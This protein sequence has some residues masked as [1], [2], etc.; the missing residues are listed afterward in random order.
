GSRGQFGWLEEKRSPQIPIPKRLPKILPIRIWKY[1]Q[2]QITHDHRQIPLHRIPHR[3]RQRVRLRPE[4][5]PP[6]RPR[7]FKLPKLPAGGSDGGAETGVT[8]WEVEEEDGGSGGRLDWT[9]GEERRLRFRACVSPYT[10][11]RSIVF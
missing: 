4:P 2:L 6:D 1:H 9:K 3:L 10:K 7:T 5:A 11:P 8:F